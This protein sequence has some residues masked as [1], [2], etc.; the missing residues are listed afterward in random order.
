MGHDVA[1]HVDTYRRWMPV[2]R[3]AQAEED[4]QQRRQDRLAEST[5]DVY[6]S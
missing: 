1:V 3:V 2:G 6:I 4:A 5:L